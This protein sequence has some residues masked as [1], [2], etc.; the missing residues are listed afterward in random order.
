METTVT[1]AKALAPLFALAL[2]ILVACYLWPTRPPAVTQDTSELSAI[3]VAHAFTAVQTAIV[4]NGTNDSGAEAPMS[5]SDAIFWNL[6]GTTVEVANV[7]EWA[8]VMNTE[9]YLR[10]QKEG[11][12]TDTAS[13]F[14]PVFE[15]LGFT[16]NVENTIQHYDGDIPE[17]INSYEKGVVKCAVVDDAEYLLNGSSGANQIS[18]IMYCSDQ[19]LVAYPTQASLR[20]SLDLSDSKLTVVQ[21]SGDLYYYD[22]FPRRGNSG[23]GYAL[24]AKKNPVGTFTK[25]YEGNGSVPCSLVA[26]YSIP[27]D[28]LGAHGC[29]E[30]S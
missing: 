14:D 11:R 29:D 17:A 21:Q 13:I 12:F 30:S 6:N 7:P 23:G 18:I 19:V 3:T 22:V 24:I 1:K 2:V 5:S 26:K 9:S 15:S 25:I 8:F 28:F 4:K 27:A 20:K 10:G 16:K